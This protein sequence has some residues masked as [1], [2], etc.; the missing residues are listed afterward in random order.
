MINELKMEH[1][2]MFAIAAFFLYH[3][4]GSCGCGNGFSVGGQLSDND[5][6]VPPIEPRTMYCGGRGGLGPIGGSSGCY[7][8]K[9]SVQCM[10]GDPPDCPDGFT[11]SGPWRAGCKVGT[12]IKRCNRIAAKPSDSCINKFDSLCPNCGNNCKKC[13]QDEAENLYEAGCNNDDINSLFQDLNLT[14]AICDSDYKKDCGS[15]SPNFRTCIS[16]WHKCD[17]GLTCSC[18]GTKCT[19]NPG[20]C[21]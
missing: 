9:N 10:W 17:K 11:D 6:P 14:G 7:D 15:L 2:L 20:T 13:Y 4:L 3:L 18:T 16:G 12:K 21:N 1:I 8:T 5:N 19:G